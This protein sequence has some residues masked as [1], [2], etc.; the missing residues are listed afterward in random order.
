MRRVPPPSCSAEKPNGAEARAL[1]AK[2]IAPAR[3]IRPTATEQL[4]LLPADTSLRGLDRFFFSLGK[5]RRLEKLLGEAAAV[6]IV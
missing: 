2:E 6:S 4:H 1:F 3:L 5:K